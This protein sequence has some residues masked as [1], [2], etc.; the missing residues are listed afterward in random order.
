MIN[1]LLTMA[2]L[3][4]SQAWA[5]KSIDLS[6]LAPRVQESAFE[7]IPA[8]KT[9]KFTAADID[10]LIRYLVVQEQYDAAQVSVEN[11]GTHQIYYLSVGRTR[12]ISAVQFMGNEEFS[13]NHIR[14]EFAVAEKSTFEQQSLI[15]G[16]ER[17]RKIYRERGYLNTIVDLEFKRVSTADVAID[18]KVTEGPQTIV[19]KV[20]V[21]AE[22]P[23]LQA[24]VQKYLSRKMEDEPLTERLLDQMRNDMRSQLSEDGYLKSELPPAELNFNENESEVTLTYNI[25]HSD[26]YFLD[27]RGVTESRKSIEEFIGYE[28]FFSSNPNV[29]LELATRI[30][31]FYLS[32]G[33]ARVEVTG[34]EEPGLRPHSKRIVITVTQGPRIQIKDIQVSG[35][36]SQPE[37]EYVSFI[38]DHSSELISDK[39]YNREDLDN[40][41][42]NLIIDRQNQGYLKARVISTR[43]IYNKEKDQ[44][45]ILV[46]L[47]EGPLTIL[48]Q[49]TFEGNT[50]YGE[51]QLKEVIGL[52]PAQPLK[53]NA[54]E[55]S[56]EKIKKFY[57]DAGYLEMVLLNEREDLVT[58][59]DESTL[60]R[61]KY[62]IF[63]GPKIVVASI[64]IE[65]NTLTKD[66]VILKELEFKVGDTL[67]PELI[68]ESVSRLQ[69]VG[70]FNSVDIK[71]LEEKTQISNRTVIVRVV[72]RDPGLFNFGVGATNQRGLT[73]RGYTGVAYRNI[74]G[75]GRGAS[76]RLEGNYNV[77]EIKYLERKIT[78]A[79]LEPYLFDT[80]V[81]GKVN[82]SQ[83]VQ[84]N[85]LDD[86]K[87]SDIKQIVWSLEQ[88]ITS[89]VLLSYDLFNSAFVRDFEIETGTKLEEL[90]INSTGPT[91]DIDYR[92]HPFNPTKGT[93][94][95]LNLEY[96]DSGIL[97]SSESIK[98]VRSF[99]SFTHYLSPWNPGWTWANSVR[100][101]YLK[102]LQPN[103]G[104][105]YDK[106]GLIL[107]G[108]STIRGF[109]PSEGFPNSIDFGVDDYVL[110]TEANMYLLKSELRFPIWGNVGGALFYDGGAVFVKGID[111]K[112]P[113]RDATGLAF[114]YATPVGAVSL[115]LG[116]KLDRREGES[117][118]PFFFS[119]GTF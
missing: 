70:H 37:N 42:K 27:L 24:D 74:G 18:V 96:A 103:G 116:Y 71:T 85:E 90:T 55:A 14:K 76:A 1:T 15:E 20:T 64:L 83:S 87:G 22:N 93:F 106:K 48:E 33:Y 4:C 31:Q 89:H 57:H 58:Y 12:R 43:T 32:R 80:R 82:Y 29:S 63:E 78:L 49:I 38:F 46:N 110:T 66:Y 104:V 30:K 47:D 53:L 108:Q 102:N 101:G 118:F 67:T 105:P 6:V 34:E 5:T 19:K 36:L 65:G 25:E 28:Q 26:E 11:R 77:S 69:R 91:L 45:S 100:G 115:E 88:D 23:K 16:G 68:E 81:R 17:I 97:G 61:A 3:F 8:L 44:L 2:L 79:Y 50:A 51:K 21:K 41:L 75:S 52:E 39:W 99:A 40:G 72:D 35:R 73:L 84:I 13:D 112:D 94:T 98:Y 107:G 95:R 119:I 113:Y 9:D 86:T 10:Q 60:A 92:D 109:Q 117:Q 59:N 56:I 114:R 54:L 111:I 7:Q 62:K